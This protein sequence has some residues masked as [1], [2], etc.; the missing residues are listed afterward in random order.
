MDPW[1]VHY[2]SHVPDRMCSQKT[3]DQRQEPPTGGKM[4]AAVRGWPPAKSAGRW[5][6]TSLRG[7]NHNDKK[8]MPTETMHKGTAKQTSIP[9]I[10]LRCKVIVTYVV[11]KGGTIHFCHDSE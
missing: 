7:Q 9:L 6:G 8:R 11:N 10:E 4:S 1:E 3:Q 5:E 2:Y